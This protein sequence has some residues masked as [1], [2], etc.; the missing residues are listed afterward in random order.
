MIERKDILMITHFNTLPGENGNSRFNFIAN[1]LATNHNVEVV[2]TN[3]SH[4]TKR[5]RELNN[6][7]FQKQKYKI[8][9]VNELGYKKNVSPMR[10]ISHYYF[11][12]NLKI[13]LSSRKKPSVIYC[14]VP[15]L[16][17]GYIAASFAKENDIKFIID[18][19]DLW[20]EAFKI[21]LKFPIIGK[22]IFG[23]MIKK[24]NFIYENADEIIGVSQTYI[25]RALSIN[26]KCKEGLS[27][28]LGTDLVYFDSIAKNIYSEKKNEEFWLVY[29]GTLGHN[30]DLKSVIEAMNIVKKQGYHKMKLKIIGNGPLKKTFVNYSK[31]LQIN[32]D[33][34]DRL[35]YEKM[36]EI[37]VQCDVAVNP[38]TKG[39][40]GSIINKVGDY[41][42]AGLPVLNTQESHEY[43]NLLNEYNAGYNCRNSDSKDLSEKIIKLYE[44]PEIKEEQ[45]K[46]N[47]RLAEDKFDRNK[48]YSALVTKVV[49][50]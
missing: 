8:T 37:L 44:N 12:K 11:G 30:Y 31:E 33:F 39:A 34:I 16:D 43:M 17:A 9:F 14:S 25:E 13:F 19:Q 23:N 6:I 18:I 47:R 1:L 50:A 46:N 28:F 21:V 5:F 35:P 45:G 26:Q 48:T 42:A 15:S 24:A 36:I 20:P 3:F 22:H 10:L 41:A 27:A 49:N 4:G 40:A 7:L 2:T 29:I 38:I 32:C